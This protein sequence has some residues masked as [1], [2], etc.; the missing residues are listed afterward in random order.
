MPYFAS[1]GYPC[2]AISLRGTGGTFAGEGVKKV[3]IEQHVQ[4]ITDFINYV[5]ESESQLNANVDS[6]PKPVLIA[7]SFGG[8]AIMKYLESHLL[9]SQDSDD[10]SSVNLPISGVVS[11]CS[12]PPSGNGKMTM[13]F[14][15][16]SLKDSWKITA[17]LA[18]KKCI[19]DEKLCRELFFDEGCDE[20]VEGISSDDLKRI[21]GYFERD[22]VATIDLMDLAKQLPSIYTDENGKATFLE[23]DIVSPN[24]VPALV[25]GAR[26]DFIVDEE[27]VVEVAKYYGVEEFMVE[28]SHDVMLD[29]RW[30]NAANKIL[31]FL[32]GEIN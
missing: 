28:S 17:G 25:I 26:D 15:K 18:M 19:N 23:N 21:Q 31:S 8:L 29:K 4:D 27:G 3:R 9:P 2:Y 12:V 6:D 16:R 5:Q 20:D 11:M 14:L 7:H 10:V 32:D 13:R 24:F 1:F 22:T 30:K